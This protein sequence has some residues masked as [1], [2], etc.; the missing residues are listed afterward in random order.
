MVDCVEVLGLFDGVDG[1]EVLVG[2]ALPE[3]L[4]SEC[5]G[6]VVLDEQGPTLRK[7]MT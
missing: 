5:S 3:R 6:G 1:N 4:G 7:L 2:G